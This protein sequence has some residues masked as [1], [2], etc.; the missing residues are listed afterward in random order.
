MNNQNE[1][2]NEFFDEFEGLTKKEKKIVKLGIEAVVCMIIVV[3]LLLNSIYTLSENEVAVVNTFGK[4]E[5]II[6]PGIHFK[7]PFI[8]TK[9]KMSSEIREMKIGYDD[10]NNT[11]ISESE[12]ITKDLNFVNADFYLEYQIV[13]AIQA[14]IHRKTAVDILKNLAQSYIR[15]EIGIHNVDDVMTTGKTEIQNNIKA[16]LSQRLEEENIGL[17]VINVSIQDIETPTTE[18]TNAFKAV[19]DAKQSMETTIN[20]AKKY[21]SENIPNA[22]AKAD[23]LIKDAEAYKQQRISEAE[24]QVAR[25]NDMYEEYVKYPLITKKRMYYEAIEEVLPELNVYIVESDNQTVLLPNSTMKGI[26][27]EK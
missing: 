13:D 16:K 25:F 5:S 15:D 24:G 9:Y 3:L 8:Q 11:I 21:Q 10:D 23:K 6:T 19:E 18:V 1:E 14:Y 7:I 26:T 27:D 12:M 2:K 4:A 17:A 22:N 20:N